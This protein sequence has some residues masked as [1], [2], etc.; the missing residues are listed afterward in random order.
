MP[1]SSSF[2]SSCCAAMAHAAGSCAAACSASSFASAL[3]DASSMLR[4]HVCC[5]VGSVVAKLGG[6]FSLLER[7]IIVRPAADAPRSSEAGPPTREKQPTISCTLPPA[8]QFRA[9]S[10]PVS[11]CCVLALLVLRA[12]AA[13]VKSSLTLFSVHRACLL[14]V[15]S[16]LLLA[17]TPPSDFQFQFAVL[18]PTHAC[19]R[20]HTHTYTHRQPELRTPSAGATCVAFRRGTHAP[21]PL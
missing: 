20:C 13:R 1:P 3:A 8:P 16:V 17:I 14:D 19:S 2:C 9:P 21:P 4:S 10:H 5:G 6:A 15:S 12:A 7:M 11:S 18:D